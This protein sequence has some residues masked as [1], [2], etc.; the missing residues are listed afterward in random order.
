MHTENLDKVESKI[1]DC[2]VVD[3]NPNGSFAN[4]PQILKRL[5]YSWKEMTEKERR[6]TAELIFNEI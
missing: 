1:S 6:E 3:K 2:G 5:F 4:P